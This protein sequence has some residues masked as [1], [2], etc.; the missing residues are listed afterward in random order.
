M[1]EKTA[2]KKITIIGC[3]L[4]GTLAL[5]GCGGKTS[6]KA[7]PVTTYDKNLSCDEIKLEMNDTF[8]LK[9]MAEENK[10]LNMR[11]VLW[12][13]G[14]PSTYMS[15]EEAIETADRRLDYLSTV[16]E[17]KGCERPL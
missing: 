17:T 13:F 12:P 8:Y 2:V 10:G 5:A 9:R 6:P 7:P 16:Y 4:L 11:N 3:A 14:Y 1:C 15:A